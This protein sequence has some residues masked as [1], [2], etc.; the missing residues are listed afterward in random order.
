MDI[1]EMSLQKLKASI[2]E[3]PDDKLLEFIGASR[4]A[5]NKPVEP[6]KRVG[7]A[8]KK[9][10]VAS[11]ESTPDISPAVAA[12]MQKLLSL[13]GGDLSKL[14]EALGDE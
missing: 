2:T 9:K 8:K 13:L 4:N 14:T 3:I 12:E 7:G 11:A 1:K 5:R 10:K 6:K